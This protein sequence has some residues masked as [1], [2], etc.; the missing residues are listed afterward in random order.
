MEIKN[1]PAQKQNNYIYVLIFG[2]YVPKNRTNE[3]FFL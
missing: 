1:L 2:T 3:T